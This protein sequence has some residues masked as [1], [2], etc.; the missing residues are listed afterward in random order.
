M[1]PVRRSLCAARQFEAVGNAAGNSGRRLGRPGGDF[2]GD[3]VERAT[4][5]R[6]LEG[7]LPHDYQIP[8]GG[9]PGRLVAAVAPDVLRPF[10]HPEGDV[11]LR[12]GRLP[13]S[14]PVPEAS[15]HVDDRL[16]P[17]N[18]DVRLARIPPVADPEPPA[19]R[20]QPPAD[21][22]LGLR[23]LAADL[24]HQTAALLGRYSIHGIPGR[25]VRMR[26]WTARTNH[27]QLA[28]SISCRRSIRRP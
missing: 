2:G 12:H 26:T 1:F 8:P 19:F 21:E 10:L 23:V 22:K 14:V 15:P 9:A 25:P 20:E 4:G 7:A 3:P 24:R 17:G 6:T 18:H 28:S 27:R 16:R 5:A 13:A 11:R